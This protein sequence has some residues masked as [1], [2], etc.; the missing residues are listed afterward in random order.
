MSKIKT[1]VIILFLST[2]GVSARELGRQSAQRWEPS[3][4]WVVAIGILEWEDGETWNSFPKAGRKDAEL[5]EFFKQA[6]VPRDQVLFLKD[7][8]ATKERI[9]RMM[10]RHLS[11]A[12]EGD[13]LIFYF[14]GHG[15][16]DDAGKTYFANYDAGD[17]LEKTAVSVQSIFRIIERNFRGDHVLLTADC[18]YS[19]A[20]AVEAAKRR[21]PISYAALTSSRAD[22]LST[23]DWTFTEALLRGF[24]GNAKVDRNQDGEIELSELAGYAKSRMWSVEGQRTAFATTR[25]FSADMRLVSV[26]T[27][28]VA[29]VNSRV[30]VEWENS[31]YPAT[32]LEVKGSRY[33]IHYLG[34]GSEWD[35][36]I[37]GARIRRA[38]APG[39]AGERLT[40]N[41]G[42]LHFTTFV[43]ASRGATIVL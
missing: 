4:T 8:E 39:A 23:A 26:A 34:Y 28:A 24:K 2:F 33:R 18:C 10:A 31:W 30:E 22:S 14:T 27:R 12:G 29:G 40:L 15:G 43:S 25:E 3:R 37:E 6:G 7:R 20:L 5:V 9:E 16:Q 17:D 38:T 35:E 32:I 21:V 19:G 36:W 13:M 11:R 1:L 42:S 41:D